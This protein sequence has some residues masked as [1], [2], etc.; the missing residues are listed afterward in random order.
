MFCKSCFAWAVFRQKRAES[1]GKRRLYGFKKWFTWS[2]EWYKEIVTV[3]AQREEYMDHA[4]P[5]KFDR[6]PIMLKLASIHESGLALRSNCFFKKK[7]ENVLV[8]N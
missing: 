1:T 3:T 5:N 4:T 7:I 8:L 6:P 2:R